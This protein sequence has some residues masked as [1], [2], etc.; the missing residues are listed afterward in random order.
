MRINEEWV[1]I[2]PSESPT[3]V[4]FVRLHPDRLPR[5]RGLRSNKQ[6]FFYSIRCHALRSL[7][8]L[9]LRARGGVSF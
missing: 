2:S 8:S 4:L 5:R 3:A 6:R 1:R 9:S 7:Y